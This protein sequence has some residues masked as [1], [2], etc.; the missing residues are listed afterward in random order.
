MGATIVQTA[1]ASSDS[2]RSIVTAGEPTGERTVATSGGTSPE[3][4]R[5]QE[6][7]N[8]PTLAS[9]LE[10]SRRSRRQRSPLPLPPPQTKNYIVKVP[11]DGL[12]RFSQ[13]EDETYEALVGA[14]EDMVLLVCDS[15]DTH[16]TITIR[17]KGKTLTL[18]IT[19]ENGITIEQPSVTIESV[20]DVNINNIFC[21]LDASG[22]GYLGISEMRILGDV[23]GF[24]GDS[25]KWYDEYKHIC[26]LLGCDI[27][28]GIGKPA[29]QYLLNNIR[30]TDDLIDTLWNRVKGTG[31]WSDAETSSDATMVG[32][33]CSPPPGGYAG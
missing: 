33:P 23:I 7:K 9:S 18:M 15:F 22:T 4:I 20:R 2:S 29:I 32:V 13:W 8:N 14:P 21:K 26:G 5:K 24:S 12:Y 28:V 25:N 11:R 3:M 10:A 17:R 19:Q 27:K 16:R 30:W 1:S 31:G 6:E